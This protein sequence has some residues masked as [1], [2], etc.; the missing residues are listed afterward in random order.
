MSH[1]T[2]VWILKLAANAEHLFNNY[3][4]DL[5]IEYV[6]FVALGRPGTSPADLSPKCLQ[7]L[8]LAALIGKKYFV[9]HDTNAMA[10]Q[11]IL[12]LLRRLVPMATTSR[13]AL[14]FG[15]IGHHLSVRRLR[16][17]VTP[18]NTSCPDGGLH[19]SL[20]RLPIVL[21]NKRSPLSQR[22]PTSSTSISSTVEAHTSQYPVTPWNTSC[23]DGG[24]HLRL[25]PRYCCMLVAR[26]QSAT[27]SPLHRRCLQLLRTEFT[28]LNQLRDL[29]HPS[30]LSG[31][32]TTPDLL[33]VNKRTPLSE[34]NTTPDQG[35]GGDEDTAKRKLSNP[36]MI[37]VVTGRKL[38][39]PRQKPVSERPV[40]RMRGDRKARYRSQSTGHYQTDSLASA[41]STS[42]F[43]ATR[44]Q[45]Q[46]EVG[47]EED[48]YAAMA[49]SGTKAQV[50]EMHKDPL[51]AK[52][53]SPPFNK[54]REATPDLAT[55]TNIQKRERRMTQWDI[56]P[57]GYE[58]I[59]AGGR[60]IATHTS[61]P[62]LCPG[63]SMDPGLRWNQFIDPNNTIVFIGGLSGYVAEDELRC[64]FRGFGEITYVKIRPDKDES[65]EWMMRRVEGNPP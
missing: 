2:N 40:L 28:I 26:A 50:L 38:S 18:W 63:Q 32:N 49:L 9:L 58:N 16:Y 42:P 34:R 64:F 20:F 33:L 11:R 35:G 4:I 52:E 39:K 60:R 12:H 61:V 48:L 25:L 22:N 14:M 21:V 47:F 10:S 45:A 23:P 59:T 17:P 6:E 46:R 37:A 41:L 54:P 43:R 53:E 44:Q 51:E 36:N 65:V 5:F 8:P 56:K 1:K 57:A 13:P 31:M 62:L 55:F 15:E 30:P 29:Q 24:L 19:V 3:N 7:P 27:T